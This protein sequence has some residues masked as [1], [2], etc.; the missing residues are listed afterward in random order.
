MFMNESETER[1]IRMQ[2][3]KEENAKKEEEREKIC[4]LG[5]KRQQKILK[6]FNYS[7][8]FF[9]VKSIFQITMTMVML[10][11]Y[12]LIMVHD[13]NCNF[14]DNGYNCPG[15]EFKNAVN[16]RFQW[17]NDWIVR[18]VNETKMYI[19][20]SFA[21]GVIDKITIIPKKFY[22][23]VDD[24]FYNDINGKLNIFDGEKIRSE[25]HEINPY[26][27]N[28]RNVQSHYKGFSCNISF[29][30]E[31][32]DC[33]DKCIEVM[34][35]YEEQQKSQDV[36]LCYYEIE[37]DAWW[38][39]LQVNILYIILYGYFGQIWSMNTAEDFVE[40]HSLDD[41]NSKY[42][43]SL[44]D[45]EFK[46]FQRKFN[47]CKMI[48]DFLV[49]L[50]VN[51]IWCDLLTWAF[52]P[53]NNSMNI[54]RN[55][56]LSNSIVDG[57]SLEYIKKM[58]IYIPRFFTFSMAWGTSFLFFFVFYMLIPAK[59][60]F[61]IANMF[62][63][64]S[65]GFLNINISFKTIKNLFTFEYTTHFFTPQFWYYF[66]VFIFPFILNF[67]LDIDEYYDS[68]KSQCVSMNEWFCNKMKKTELPTIELPEISVETKEETQKVNENELQIEIREEN[69]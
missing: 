29:H 27:Y 43:G 25:I 44:D 30:W 28:D 69:I 36:L 11:R 38:H 59:I 15:A 46:W 37:Y 9:F 67:I 22:Y 26:R 55:V 47:L 1:Q 34:S 5:E 66:N 19:P 6:K 57:N 16:N 12:G 49:N 61:S 13:L 68:I 40:S 62:S 24:M 4:E 52:N 10:N 64:F 54:Y 31:N 65:V 14:R 51:F 39:N 60:I 21:T 45:N 3:I 53:I 20:V 42:L 8:F 56:L 58:N 2:R 48:F 35:K 41:W 7:F 23:N 17:Y 18:N 50:L 33:D 32:I 63:V